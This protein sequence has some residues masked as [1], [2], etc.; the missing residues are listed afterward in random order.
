MTLGPELLPRKPVPYDL[1]Q[2]GAVATDS[3]NYR[4]DRYQPPPVEKAAARPESMQHGSVWTPTQSSAGVVAPLVTNL[5]TSARRRWDGDRRG[6]PIIRNITDPT[7]LTAAIVA[8][9]SV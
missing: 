8:K 6:F 7:A 9:G 1:W 2:P 3:D 4:P 5:C